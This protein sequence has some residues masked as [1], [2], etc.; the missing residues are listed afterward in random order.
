MQLT[1]YKAPI[2]ETVFIQRASNAELRNRVYDASASVDD[3]KR[4]VRFFMKADDKQERT[5]TRYAL[6]RAC[7][8]EGVDL[9]VEQLAMLCDTTVA[10]VRHYMRKFDLGGERITCN[11]ASRVMCNIADY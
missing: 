9:T 8:R 5:M 2:T 4:F 7:Y 1:T 6:A 10:N 11:D 3:V